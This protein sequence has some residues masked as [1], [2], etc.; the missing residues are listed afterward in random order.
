MSRVTVSPPKT[1]RST[2][3]NFCRIDRADVRHFSARLNALFGLTGS[4][5]DRFKR[6]SLRDQFF[7]QHADAGQVAIALHEIE[8]VTDNDFILD[9]KPDVIGVDR[10]AALL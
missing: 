10:G 9:L 6:S 3:T 1:R 5:L 8:P 7:P 4:K 2:A